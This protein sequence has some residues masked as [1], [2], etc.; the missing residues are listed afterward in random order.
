[1]KTLIVF[2]PSHQNA[3]YQDMSVPQIVESIL[4]ERHEMRGQDFLFDF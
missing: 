2:I 4:R 3:I 1:M